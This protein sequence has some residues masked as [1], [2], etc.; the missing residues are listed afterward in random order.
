MY[1]YIYTHTHARIHPSMHADIPTCARKVRAYITCVP[2]RTHA[3]AYMHTCVHTHSIAR[4]GTSKAYME[5]E[6]THRTHTKL[7]IRV[8]YIQQTH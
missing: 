1:I 5:N 7:H 4:P 2:T 8:R 3:H 6:E